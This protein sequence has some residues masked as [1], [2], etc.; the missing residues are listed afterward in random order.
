MSSL[1]FNLLDINTLGFKAAE[2]KWNFHSYRPGLVGSHC[3]GVD[4]YY[5]TYKAQQLGYLPE[6]NLLVEELIIL[7]EKE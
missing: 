4:P 1:L 6:V 7:W 3:I 2:T 5:L